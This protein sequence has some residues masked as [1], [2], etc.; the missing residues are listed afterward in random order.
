MLVSTYF[1]YCAPWNLVDTFNGRVCRWPHAGE[2]ARGGKVRSIKR[3]LSPLLRCHRPPRRGKWGYTPAAMWHSA[4]L[5]L[6]KRA[7]QYWQFRLFWICTALTWRPVLYCTVLYCAVLYWPG[8]PE[9]WMKSSKLMSSI[10]EPPCSLA[11][12]A[13][14]TPSTQHHRA[15]AVIWKSGNIWRCWGVYCGYNVID[16]GFTGRGG[17]KEITSGR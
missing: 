5:C 12:P 7:W 13:S 10:K 9:L 8:D 17:K 14:P 2:D 4:M 1:K 15:R 11:A 16:N 6:H 3:E